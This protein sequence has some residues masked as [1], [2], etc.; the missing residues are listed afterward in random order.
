MRQALLPADMANHLLIGTA[1][2]TE[3]LLEWAEKPFLLIDDGRIADAFLAHF[4]AA[5]LFDVAKHTFNPLRGIDTIRAREFA[6][7]VYGD[8]DLMTYR[9]GKRA[10]VKMLCGA[11]RLDKLPAIQHK[12][13]EDASATIDDILMSPLLR[14]VLCTP[15]NFSF[16]GVVIAKLDRAVLGDFDA[17]LLASLLIG[18]VQGQVIIPDFGFSGRDHHLALIRQKRLCAAVSYLGELPPRLRNAALL[19]EDKIGDHCLPEDAAVLAQFKGLVPDPTRDDSEYNLFI[20]SC[21][22]GL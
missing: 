16:K 14:N 12:G 1:D 22:R 3:Q 18:Q 9:D 20:R 13:Y 19:I 8:K 5:K 10:L 11:K 21:V 17:F 6:E 2:K 7:A 15:P 4:P